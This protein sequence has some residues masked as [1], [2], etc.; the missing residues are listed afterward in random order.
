MFYCYINV[1]C[2][3]WFF[4]QLTRKERQFYCEE[5]LKISASGEGDDNDSV[6]EME[7]DESNSMTSVS[8][9]CE[10]LD[11]EEEIVLEEDSIQEV[12]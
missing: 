9:S 11:N 10:I 4:F 12:N 1:F 3:K 2:N 6:V 7:V 8:N 5:S